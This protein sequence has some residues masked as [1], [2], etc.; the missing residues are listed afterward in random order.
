MK[1]SVIKISKKDVER[2]LDMKCSELGIESYEELEEYAEWDCE[3]FQ[4]YSDIRHYIFLLCHFD[5]DSHG[6]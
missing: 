2:W 5:R 4:E 3:D 1:K 6:N